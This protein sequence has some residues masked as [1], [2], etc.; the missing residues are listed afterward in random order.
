MA[1]VLGIGGVFFKANDPS[2]LIDWYSEVLEIKMSAYG[3][4]FQRDTLPE[5][6]FTAFS[7][8]NKTTEYFQPS[9]QEYLIN[10]I[11][12][13]LDALLKKIEAN[14]GVLCGTPE[15]DELGKFGWFLD[16]EGN[17]VELWQP[18]EHDS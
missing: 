11:V 17:K 5:G 6:S 8:F 4:T 14:G 2:T 12:D 15:E 3:A 7:I 9:Q 13:D 16:P 10:F 1:R 18:N